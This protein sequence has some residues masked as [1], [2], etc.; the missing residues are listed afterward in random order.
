MM[1]L[2]KKLKLQ[3]L[4]VTVN[5]GVVKLQFTFIDKRE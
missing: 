1:K 3:T 4:T 5:L 2:I